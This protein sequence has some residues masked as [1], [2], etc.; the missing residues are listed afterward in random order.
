MKATRRF[1]AVMLLLYRHITRQI[2]NGKALSCP[3]NGTLPKP[4]LPAFTTCRVYPYALLVVCHC[5]Y[6]LGQIQRAAL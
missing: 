1:V 3:C 2:G 5:H 6:S 4:A